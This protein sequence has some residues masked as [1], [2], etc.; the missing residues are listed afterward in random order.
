VALIRPSIIESRLPEIGRLR[1]GGPKREMT[2]RKGEKFMGLGEDL[3]HFRFDP[4]PSTYD[5]PSPDGDGRLADYLIRQYDEL[6]VEP[7]TLPIQFMHSEL[8]KNFTNSNEVWA[9]VGAVE[10]C[11]RRCDGQTQLLHLT[12]DKKLSK[13]PIVCAAEE[14][15]N[16]CPNKCKPTGRL[17]FILPCLKYPGLVVMTTHSIYDII[18]IQGNLA[19]YEGWDLNKIPFQLCRTERTI[20]RNDN[21]DIKPMKK[22]LCHLVIDPRFGNAVLA[23]QPKQYLA[24]LTGGFD[25]E[26][27]CIDIIPVQN[28][29]DKELG[30]TA[31]KPY[32][33]DRSGQQKIVARICA[34]AKEAGFTEDGRD[35][36]LREGRFPS[37]ND[38]TEADL[39]NV[40]SWFT[41]EA[42]DGWNKQAAN[43]RRLEAEE[44]KLVASIAEK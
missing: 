13:A 35:A 40:L 3:N 27:D 1:K 32:V 37:K 4:A 39:P 38:V 20:N 33:E 29:S 17:S 12:D 44:R 34:V 11:I 43:Q 14:G 2:N 36:M 28:V 25:D 21:G 15:M 30:S 24:E 23:A 42:A 8:S 6:G 10:R 9:K 19:L 16:E 31:N 18:E 26:D 7:R 5:L 22:W 41:P